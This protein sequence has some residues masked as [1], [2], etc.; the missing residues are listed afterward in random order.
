MRALVVAVPCSVQSLLFLDDEGMP[1]LEV[2]HGSPVGDEVRHRDSCDGSRRRLCWSGRW[3]GRY[4]SWSL[5]FIGHWVVL[6]LRRERPEPVLLAARK[7]VAIPGT[8]LA[9]TLARPAGRRAAFGRFAPEL[10]STSA[11]L[12]PGKPPSRRSARSRPSFWR[13]SRQ[14]IFGSSPWLPTFYRR[15]CVER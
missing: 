15:S 6:L 5:W 7:R 4:R 3:C 10:Q 11:K 8:A 14:A 12:E 9:L 13:S 2:P 1:R